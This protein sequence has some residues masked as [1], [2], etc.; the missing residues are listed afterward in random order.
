MKVSELKGAQ[1]DYWV[2]K[3][4]NVFGD[5]VFI[6]RHPWTG[7]PVAVVYY[8]SPEY[9][10]LFC[11]ERG[12]GATSF[13]P[14]TDWAQGGPLFD[15]HEIFVERANF[16]MQEK[17]FAFIYTKDGKDIAAQSYGMT[18]LEAGMRAFVE[19]KYGDEVPDIPA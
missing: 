15:A 1:L 2:A 12:H 4:M 18:R 9:G 14:S 11:G 7:L 8:G 6:E 10:S 3:S 5:K 13:R 16:S 19:S 17:A